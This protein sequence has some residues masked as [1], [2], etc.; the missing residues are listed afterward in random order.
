MSAVGLPGLTLAGE[1][2]AQLLPASVRAREKARAGRRMMGFF[3]VVAVVVAGGAT[4]WAYLTQAAAQTALDQASAQTADLVAQQAQYADATRLAEIVTLTA[5]AE[6]TVTATE[7]QWLPL[8]V[9]I[10]RYVPSDV[11]LSG[12]ALQAPPPW[13]TALVPEGPLRTAR[14]AVVTL[15]FDSAN[16]AS[17]A[18]FAA[19][20]PAMYGFADVKINSTIF[21]SGVYTSNVTVT[22]TAEAVSG[23]FSETS[24][25][26]AATDAATEEGT[27]G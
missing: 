7:I 24:A 15:E 20:I 3:V 9:E 26:P 2:R 13:E 23:R 16:F 22:L 11:A 5:A 12:I 6:Q 17:I 14:S 8:M 10:S 21:E 19:A 27:D 25:T 1:P 4:G 18:A